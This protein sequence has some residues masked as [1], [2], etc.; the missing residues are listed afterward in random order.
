M[1]CDYF[2]F[3]SPTIDRP[4][5]IYLWGVVD[6]LHEKYL[7]FPASEFE[8]TI[9]DGLPMST[10]K[11]VVAAMATYYI[12][13]FGGQFIMKNS[14]PIRLNKLFQLHNLILTLLSLIL[15]VLVA[16]Q[17]IP[18]VAKH[19]LFYLICS[20]NCWTTELVYLYYLNYLTKYL[21]FLDTGYI[22]LKKRPVIFLHWF[23][24]SMTAL[25]CYT[26]LIGKFIL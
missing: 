14:G 19:G 21:E 20:S 15:A 25:L 16:E 2:Q 3:E 6:K 11:E 23:H 10:W 18:I 4:F 22:I 8:F 13:V 7:G 1:V 24:H 9:G 17:V 26:Q 5:G 12:M